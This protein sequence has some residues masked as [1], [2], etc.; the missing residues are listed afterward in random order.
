MDLARFLRGGAA[1]RAPAPHEQVSIATAILHMPSPRLAAIAEPGV[2]D[3][4]ETAIAAGGGVLMMGLAPGDL[5]IANDRFAANCDVRL[6]TRT[7][8]QVR[9][10]GA[11]DAE[12]RVSPKL[13]AL[14]A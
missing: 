1:L 4:L 5:E 6:T 14:A 13:A 11:I 3:P 8:L 2:R 9:I 12:G 10:E 7:R